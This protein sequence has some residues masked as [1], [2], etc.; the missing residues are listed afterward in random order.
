L[1]ADQLKPFDYLTFDEK[2]I[3]NVLGWD[4]KLL[5][6]DA[7]AKYD[8]V[9]QA[10][11]RVITD[12]IEPDLTALSEAFTEQF[13]PMFASTRGYELCFDYSELP[14]MQDD[15]TKLNQWLSASLDRGVITRNEYRVALGYQKM[16]DPDMDE[17]SVNFDVIKLS[18]AIEDDY[19]QQQ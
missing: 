13:L 7:G 8:N 10:R 16:D 18:D 11:K 15:L 4:D 19:G 9:L 12:N 17:V 2:Q 3:C 1:S 14:E 6:N 5:N